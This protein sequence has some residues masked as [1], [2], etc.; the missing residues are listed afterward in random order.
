[1][2]VI[3]LAIPDVKIIRPKKFGDSRGFFSETYSKKAFEAAGLHYDFV[4]DNQSLSAEVGTV[5]GL[6]FQLAPFAQ[7]KLV[8]VV[9]GAI[10]DVAVD[11]RKGSPTYGQHVSAVISAEEWNQ[12]LVPIGFAHGFCTLEPDTEVI[13]KVTNFYSAEHDRGLLWNDPDLGIDWPV[14]ADKALLSD[15]DR[16]QPR[17][18]D[19]G[20]WF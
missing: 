16:K 12:I 2:D 13:Y 8:R 10:L 6:H 11:I 5:R 14:A 9:K 20:D 15:K 4:Q 18:A 17:L 1:M 7:D 3:S 19:L